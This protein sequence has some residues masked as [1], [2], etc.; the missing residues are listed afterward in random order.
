MDH[1]TSTLIRSP[2]VTFAL[3][4]IAVSRPQMRPP[5]PL[6]P[7]FEMMSVY[8]TDD[9]SRDPH[10]I[11]GNEARFRRKPEVRRRIDMAHEFWIV[12]EM[13]CI[14]AEMTRGE[15]DRVELIQIVQHRRSNG[16]HARLAEVI[17]SL[18]VLYRRN[19]L[20]RQATAKT[21]CFMRMSESTPSLIR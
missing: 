18:Q 13:A 17:V 7:T 3:I 10:I 21:Q 19:R 16:C 2:A 8:R 12:I 4:R 11:S 6:E 9:K 5:F 1:E 15:R 14:R 20:T